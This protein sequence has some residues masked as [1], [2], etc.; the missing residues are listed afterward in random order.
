MNLRRVALAGGLGL[1]LL[2]AQ[3]AAQTPEPAASVARPKLGLVLSGGGARGLAHV[4]VLKVLE[5]E[6]VPV[7]VIA[8][9]SMGA[10]IGGLYAS[11]MTADE[12]ERELLQVRWDRVFASRVDRQQ[13]SQ[14]RKEEDF[15]FS[16][17][18][19]LGLRDGELRAPQST[20]SSR[21]LEAL[22][23]RLTLPVRMVQRFD[24]LPIPFRAVATD[25]EDGHQVVVGEGDLALAMRSSMSVPGVF[26][27]IE[28][29][30]RILGD[31]GLVNNLPVDI[32]RSM[33]AE[34]VI[35]VNVGTPL[36]ARSAL[37]SVVGL[38]GQMVNILTEQNV[39]R[40]LASLWMEDLL[41][42]PNLGKL[43]SADFERTRDF[44][45]QGE[46]AAEALLP[47]LRA[48]ALSEKDYVQWRLARLPTQPEAPSLEAVVFEGSDSTHPERFK[49]Q[50]ET[51]PGQ[52]FDPAKAERDTRKLASSGDYVRVD[53]HVEQRPEGDTLVFLMEDKPW[54]PNYF[55]VGLDLSTNF[56]GESSFNL[57]LSHNRHWLTEHGT[58]WRNQLTVGQTPRYY[59]ELYHPL[60]G[61]LDKSSDW[62]LSGWAE[63]ERRQITLYDPDS[64]QGLARLARQSGQLGLDLGQPWAQLGEVRFGL[65]HQRW[66]IEPKLLAV[67]VPDELLRQT[68]S[69]TGVRLRTVV[70]QLD[71]ANFPQRGYRVSF[72]AIAGLQ[73]GTNTR[74]QHFS[75]FELLGT[76]AMSSGPHTL[77]LSTRLLQANQPSDSTQGPYTLGGFQQLSGYQ[78]GQLYGNTLAFGRA[79]YYLRMREAPVLTRGFFVGGSLEAGNAWNARTDASFKD[80]RY[81]ASA[82]VGA[83]T[84]LGPLYL[85][86]GHAPRGGTAVYL[87]IGRP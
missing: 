86:L 4:G 85:A 55:R 82:F 44:I 48:L 67:E 6:R 19:E 20:I 13:L 72:D 69:E 14:R 24:K 38:T 71:F 3:V 35:A 75:R 27:P 74:R 40:S 61:R 56:A 34:Q 79:T 29:N 76:A 16:P 80:L 25:M 26:A 2:A 81:A 43:T 57:R 50:L 52:M 60:L 83:D 49:A 36:A 33:G 12:L 58:E 18:L 45:S 64:G 22:L 68:W 10:I 11:G 53:Y 8:G 62:F 63:L 7:D 78:P 9:T 30:E 37:S 84:G 28:W 23:R 21:G 66:R 31:G 1:L 51:Q 42:T 70:D 15:E 46:A 39:Q 77:N 17:V 59:T 65:T 47:R 54:G 73:S 41:I 5:R 32:A 87:F